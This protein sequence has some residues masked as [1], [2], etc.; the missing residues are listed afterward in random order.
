MNDASHAVLL[1][2]VGLQGLYGVMLMATGSTETILLTNLHLRR[3]TG[4]GFIG[5]ETS[6]SEFPLPSQFGERIA[7]LLPGAPFDRFATNR[8]GGDPSVVDGMTQFLT[9]K[10]EGRPVIQMALYGFRYPGFDSG[11]LRPG[12]IEGAPEIEG[13]IWDANAAVHEL[14]R[15]IMIDVGRRGTAPRRLRRFSKRGL[16]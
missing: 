6:L 3:S 12:D 11:P 10:T 7:K 2:A 4:S 9:V 15:E 8:V 14:W 1:E 13:D 16:L 5:G